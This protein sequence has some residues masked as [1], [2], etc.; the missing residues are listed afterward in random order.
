VP[1]QTDVLRRR[2]HET[3]A[4]GNKSVLLENKLALRTESFLLGNKTLRMRAINY[5]PE[6]FR[7]TSYLHSTSNRRREEPLRFPVWGKEV[8]DINDR[9]WKECDMDCVAE[10]SE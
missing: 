10:L 3:D 6:A 5:Y 9:C 1:L 4:E 2:V 7:R 8:R